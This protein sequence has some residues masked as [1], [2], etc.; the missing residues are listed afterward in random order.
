MKKTTHCAICVEKQSQNLA[1]YITKKGEY[2]YVFQLVQQSVLSYASHSVPQ[3]VAVHKHRISPWSDGTY[4][5]NRP[6]GS[7]GTARRARSARHPRHT[8]SNGCNR[9]AR[10]YRSARSAR[11]AGSNRRN[12]CNR[13]ARSCRSARS[14]RRNGCNWCNWR[15]RSAR[16]YRSCRS[17][18]SARRSGGNGRSRSTRSCRSARS[19]RR[20]GHS[21]TCR[22]TLCKRRHSIGS[23]RSDNPDNF[24]GNH[25]NH[26][27]DGCKQRSNP[28]RRHL[29]RHLRRNGN[30]RH[31]NRNY[32][33]TTLCKRRRDCNGNPKRRSKSHGIRKREQNHRLQ[34]Y[35]RNDLVHS[36]CVN[37]HDKLHRRKYHRTKTRLRHSKQYLK[38]RIITETAFYTRKKHA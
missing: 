2:P 24:D 30:C 1:P 27:D 38:Q 13:S 6:Y 14:A 5:R 35:C 4:R 12:G 31:R 32:V 22:R 34:R 25:S 29:Y 26:H 17:A 16:S 37:R 18:R 23:D 11:R 19:A 28:S 3:L 10:S 21:R 36:Q 33:R 7:D 20:S 8:R 15:N 9:S